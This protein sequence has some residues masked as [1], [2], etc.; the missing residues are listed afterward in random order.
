MVEIGKQ[1]LPWHMREMTMGEQP[2][3]FAVRT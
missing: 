3:L 2:E 1:G